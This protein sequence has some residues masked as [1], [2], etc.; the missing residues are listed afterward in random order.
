MPHFGVGAD[1]P[2]LHQKIQSGSDTLILRL[3]CLDEQ[4]PHAHIAYA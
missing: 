4:S 3:G 1:L 2:F